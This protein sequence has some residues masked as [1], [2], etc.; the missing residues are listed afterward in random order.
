MN[1]TKAVD[2]LSAIFHH[3]AQLS[4]PLPSYQ[5][6]INIRF[7]SIKLVQVLQISLIYQGHKLK[8]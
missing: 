1:V 6:Q 4:V 3:S 8:V 7:V 5:D 2:F